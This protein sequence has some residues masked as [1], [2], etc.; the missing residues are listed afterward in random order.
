MAKAKSVGSK[1]LKREVK[2][3]KRRYKPAGQKHRK[4]TGPKDR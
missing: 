4:K 1:G 3:T 2:V